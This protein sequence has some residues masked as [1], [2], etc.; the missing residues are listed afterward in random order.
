MIEIR[1]A[2]KSDVPEIYRLIKEL[3]DYEKTPE[4]VLI[5]VPELEKDGFGVDPSYFA[6]IAEDSG[7]VAGMALSYVKYSTWKG[8]CIYLDD[9]IVSEPFRGQGI[10]KL[11]FNEV[12]KE[13]KLLKARKLEWQVLKWNVPAIN[14][15]NKVEAIY[16]DEWLNCKLNETQLKNYLL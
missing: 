13:T 11:L 7:T 9:I 6:F 3:A 5:S 12:V 8:K 14:F 4:E 10:G 15:Y 1:K 16:D 2:R